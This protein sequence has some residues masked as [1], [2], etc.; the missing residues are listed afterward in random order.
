MEWKDDL[1][2]GNRNRKDHSATKE[3]SHLEDAE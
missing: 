3:E 2:S 1:K